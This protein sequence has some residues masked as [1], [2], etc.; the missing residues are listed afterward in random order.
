MGMLLGI[1]ILLSCTFAG[2]IKSANYKKREKFFEEFLSFNR[3]MMS[4]INYSKNSLPEVLS[5]K[6]GESE[7]EKV[8]KE[9]S[10][11]I[12]EGEVEE[13]KYLKKEENEFMNRYFSN[14]GRSDSQT[15]SEL[16]KAEEENIKRYFESARQDSLKYSG[17]Y[18]KM[19]LLIGLAGL[20]IL[21]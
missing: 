17:M 7:F 10:E 14:L 1:F 4:E 2:Y 21:V 5:E 19:G 18:V 20:I 13:R 3:Q 16:L 15:Q 9:Y 8:L 11:K 6:K 12:S